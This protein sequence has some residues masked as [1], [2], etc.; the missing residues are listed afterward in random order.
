MKQLHII[1][2]RDG[3]ILGTQLSNS[4]SRA[5]HL[6]ATR[7]N[8]VA[9]QLKAVTFMDWQPLKVAGADQDPNMGGTR[10]GEAP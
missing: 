9:S 7:H 2:D 4:P 8:L 6:F 5:C 1:T 10:I 3:N